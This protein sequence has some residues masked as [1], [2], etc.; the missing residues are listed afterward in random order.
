MR[1]LIIYSILTVL[2][3]NVNASVTDTIQ[4]ISGD[5]IA[6]DCGDTPESF[7]FSL[8]G[9]TLAFSGQI[10]ANSCG[11]HFLIYTIDSDTIHL[12]RLDT[13][14]GCFCHCL[15]NFEAKIPGCCRNRYRITLTEYFD[16]G[17]DTLIYR[18]AMNI[19]GRPLNKHGI[20]SI[21]PN[22]FIGTARIETGSDNELIEGITIY[23]CFGQIVRNE[24]GIKS[25]VHEFHRLN[26]SDG[27]Y[28]YLIRTDINNIY[29]GR[30]IVR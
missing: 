8:I 7:N 6:E 19:S 1:G 2:F 25:K 26:L 30:I 20:I 5:C 28:Y 17:L 18:D 14:A 11:E 15:Y 23:N 16:N 22:P 13:G 10:F 4:H 27:I 3:I 12:S 21:S 9:D 29:T 24:E